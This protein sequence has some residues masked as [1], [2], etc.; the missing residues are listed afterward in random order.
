MSIYPKLLFGALLVLFPLPAL[1]VGNLHIGKLQIHPELK[2]SVTYDSNIFQEPEDTREDF[3]HTIRPGVRILYQGIGDNML[4]VGYDMGFIQYTENTDNS[5]NEHT[6]FLK[7]LYKA[8]MGIFI[9]IDD[10]FAHTADPYGNSNSYREGD[11]KVKR[12]YNNL[13]L[14]LGYE[15]NRLSFEAS[16]ANHYEHYFEHEDWWQNRHDHQFGFTTYYRFLPRTSAL[17]QYRLTDFNY[18][19]QDNGDN[20]RGIESDTSQDARLHQ[21]FTGLRFDPSGK[22]KGELKVGIGRKDYVNDQD[23]NGLDYEDV[24]T[25]MAETSLTWDAT[26]KTSLETLFS[27]SLN[28]ST[29]SYATRFSRTAYRLGVRHHFLEQ[30]IG[31]TQVGVVLDD[32]NNIS[33]TLGTRHDRTLRAGA[34][35]EYTV[36][37][38]LVLT[39]SYAFTDRVS[40]EDFD[41]EEYRDHST[42]VG[43]QA[44]F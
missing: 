4:A 1:A 16:Y 18:I 25:W 13:G 6:A 29:Q 33:T 30:L 39:F 8:P 15:L 44:I 22:L 10:N 28:D 12:W 24:T 26:A 23:W 32:Y 9:R 2:Y 37:E 20:T 3:I 17:L 19:N 36:Q 41:D 40:T 34:G 14:A 43:L 38:W 27:R 7:G 21:I 35:L 42:T 31:T 5:Y 11:P